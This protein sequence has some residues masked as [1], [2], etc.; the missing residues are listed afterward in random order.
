MVNNKSS[1]VNSNMDDKRLEA[2]YPEDCWFEEIEK[3]LSFVKKGQSIQLIGIPGVGRS[4]LLGLLSY[5]R[6]VRIKHLGEDEQV[7]Y[8]FVLINF[9]EI[10]NKPLSEVMKLI[11][12]SL[13]DSLRERRILEDYEKVDKIFKDS[14][15]IND[16]QVIFQGLK[17]TIDLLALEK[18]LTVTLLF[19]RF[20]E[21]TPKISQEFFANLRALRNRAKYKFSA[22]FSLKRPIED[23]LE[24]EIYF[25]FNEFLQGNTVYLPI[26]DKPSLDFRISHLEGIN[27]RKIPEDVIKK[28]L[29]LTSGHGKL[30]RLLIEQLTIYNLQFTNNPLANDKIITSLSEIWD[31]FTPQEQQYL[32]NL[33]DETPQH[34]LNVFV[35]NEKKITIPLFSEFVKQVKPAEEKFALDSSINEIKRGEVVFSNGLTALE[36]KL[37]KYL[38]ENEGKI[39]SR[40]EV[41]NAVWADLKSTQGVTDQ[42]IDQLIFR[43]RKKVEQDPNSPKL[44]QTIK[45]RGVTFSH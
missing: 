8:H 17:E 43:L 12:L 41:I 7:K 34:L 13:V 26:S 19:D 21:Y 11:F 1:I 28:I 10:R 2:L 42:A 29:N 24:P 6:N 3:I 40:D 4:N 16:E 33:Q 27:N 22:I 44:I 36:F 18:D 25:D 15:S 31:S 32:K 23:I 45:G 39:L 38:I 37:F 14:I 30:T 9:S 20:E 5:N 35:V